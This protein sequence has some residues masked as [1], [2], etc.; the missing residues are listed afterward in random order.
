MAI[1]SHVSRAFA[2]YREVAVL[3]FTRLLL[4]DVREGRMQ[5]PETNKELEALV[6]ALLRTPF[7]T[8]TL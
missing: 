7:S 2:I 5:F 6:R 8:S 4:N 1:P 3:G